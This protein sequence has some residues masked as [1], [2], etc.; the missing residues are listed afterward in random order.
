ML[1]T[2]ANGFANVSLIEIAPQSAA[3][4]VPTLPIANVDDQAYPPIFS[5]VRDACTQAEL[6]AAADLKSPSLS[7][8]CALRTLAPL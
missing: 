5:D 1:R 4:A 6:C 8:V 3:F 2:F 7:R